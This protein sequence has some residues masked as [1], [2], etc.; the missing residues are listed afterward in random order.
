MSKAAPIA[1]RIEALKAELAQVERPREPGPVPREAMGEQERGAKEGPA[2]ES[3][4]EDF[5]RSG[6]M[7]DAAGALGGAGAAADALVKAH[8]LAAT[9]ACLLAGLIIGSVWRRRP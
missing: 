3:P 7:R 6:C 8:P 2:G 1:A 9:G 4:S 5:P